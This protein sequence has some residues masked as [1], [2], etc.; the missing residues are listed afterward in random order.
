MNAPHALGTLAATA[1]FC[2]SFLL[3]RRLHLGR[4]MERRTV[5]SIAGGAAV[6]YVF[7]DLSP[8]LQVAASAFREATS[9]LEMRVLRVGV[10][11]A[12]MVGFLFFYGVEELV[13][14]SRDERERQRWREAGVSHPLFLTHMI[15]FSAYAWIVSY[16]LVRSLPQTAVQLA[17]YAG[18]MALHFLSVAHGLR[19]EHG[20]LYDRIGARV[21]AASC[22]AG[23]VCGM[24][25]GL[26]ETVI[27]LLL[28]GVAGG[29][30][31]N[32]LTS[33]LPR[34]KQGKFIPFVV[35]A[36]AYAALLILA[37]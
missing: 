29:V 21:L 14:R 9:H 4:T 24:A 33:E 30:V 19:E 13:I 36:L 11:L 12:M 34:E 2:I 23:W 37:E 6:A 20:S 31:A 35:G 5:V 27:A 28:G 25:V 7:V 8:E 18:A 1:L 17:F 22:A 32:T 3:G 16:L 10:N 15:A 26:P